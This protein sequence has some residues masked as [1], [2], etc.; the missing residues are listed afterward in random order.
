[1]SEDIEE[2][3]QMFGNSSES[4]FDEIIGHIEDLLVGQ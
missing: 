1:M 2:E 3:I 4:N